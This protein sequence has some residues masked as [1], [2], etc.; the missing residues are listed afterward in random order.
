M[1][2]VTDKVA[3]YSCLLDTILV[4]MLVFVLVE[5]TL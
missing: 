4:I 5:L 1:S 2:W 3:E